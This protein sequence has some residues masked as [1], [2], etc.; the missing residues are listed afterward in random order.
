[1]VEP[2]RLGDSLEVVGRQLGLAPPDLV[3]SLREVW[4]AVAGRLAP[5]CHPVAVRDGTLTVLVDDSALI[6]S[7]AWNSADW[8]RRLNVEVADLGL[9]RVVAR[10]RSG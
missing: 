7:V 2:R 6:E 3:E 5:V 9:V 1:V 4:P 8:C 10:R